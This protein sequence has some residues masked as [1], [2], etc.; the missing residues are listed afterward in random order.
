[1]KATYR[2]Y[3]GGGGSQKVVDQCCLMFACLFLAQ[4]GKVMVITVRARND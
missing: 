4:N 1:M 3:G 2:C